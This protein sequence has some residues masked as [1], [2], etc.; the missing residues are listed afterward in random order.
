MREPLTCGFALT[1]GRALAGAD[2]VARAGTTP[3]TGPDG[4]CAVAGWNLWKK[5][6]RTRKDTPA[7]RSSSAPLVAD[8]NSEIVEVRLGVYAEPHTDQTQPHVNAAL[9]NVSVQQV[10][11]EDGVENITRLQVCPVDQSGVTGLRIAK[12]YADVSVTFSGRPDTNEWFLTLT[13]YAGVEGMDE[14]AAFPVT[15]SLDMEQERAVRLVA[16]LRRSPM[17]TLED[18]GDVVTVWRMAEAAHLLDRVPQPH[19]WWQP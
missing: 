4:V 16:L 12:Q 3:D 15:F 2:L 11:F 13:G 7:T 5:H 14:L 10:E 8:L 17:V 9:V 6:H 18:D 1:V 19:V